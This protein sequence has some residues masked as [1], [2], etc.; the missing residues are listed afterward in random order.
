MDSVVQSYDRELQADAGQRLSCAILDLERF[1][2]RE[3]C[4]RQGHEDPTWRLGHRL[5]EDA[6]GLLRVAFGGG[7]ATVCESTLR[8]AY[9]L[10]GAL[11]NLA[12]WTAPATH[13]SCALNSFPVAAPRD[14]VAYA[15]YGCPDIAAQELAYASMLG[16]DAVHARLLLT[17]S[18]MAAYALIENF[19]LRDVAAPGD[20]V[21]LHPGVYFETQLQLKSLKCLEITTARGGARTDMLQA[22]A[23]LQPKIVF[24]D[25][26]TNSIDFRAIDMVRLLDE[27]DRLCEGETWFVVDGTLLS[28]AFDPFAARH[29]RHVR[30]LY[31]ESGCKYLQFGM[32][33]GPAGVVVVETRLAERL[34]QLRRGTGAIASA[35]LVLPRASRNAYLDYLCAQTACALAVANAVNACAGGDGRR[36]IQ[37]AHPLLAAHP[38]CAEVQAYRHLGGVLVFRFTRD[39]LNRRRPLDAFIDALMAKALIRELPL[40]AGVSFGFRVPRIGAA[41]SSYDADRAFLRLS[42]GVDLPHAAELG[43]LIGECAQEFVAADVEAA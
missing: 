30:I 4:C 15:R 21:L 14:V 18:G 25:P 32:D 27:A 16:F 12:A 23:A 6:R 1:L 9:R 35:A 36:L 34:L 43:R 31:Y 2:R 3:E 20:R 11:A 39:S 42:A 5:A 24:V 38:D 40:T 26:L 17:S 13:E 41:W 28:G 7:A 37:P 22:I 33:L 19:L 29:R 10:S 8:S